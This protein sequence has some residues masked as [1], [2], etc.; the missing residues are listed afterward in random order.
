MRPKSR[1]ADPL[2]AWLSSN[3]VFSQEEKNN[4][5][6]K[7]QLHLVNAKSTRLLPNC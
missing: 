1:I 5:P 2:R 6:Q 7:T 4:G 3:D